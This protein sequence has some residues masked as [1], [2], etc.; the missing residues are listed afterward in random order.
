MKKLLLAGAAFAALIAGPAMAADLGAPVYRAPA[1]Y[2]PVASWTGFYAGFNTGYGWEN[3]SSTATPV[4]SFSS[5]GIT[6]GGVPVVPP[7]AFSQQLNGP[8]FGLH[9]GYNYQ[10]AS[11]V[12]GVEGDFDWAGLNNSAQFVLPDPLL[13]SG[14]TATDGFMAHQSI[15]WL[16]SIRGRLGYAWGASL[17]YVTGGGAWEKVNTNYLLS[18]DTAGG[19]FAESSAASFSNT[20]SG[21]VVGA[22]Y[23][24][25]IN[26]NWI[27]RGEYLHYGFNSG[28]N[29]N[30]IFVACAVGGAA[31]VCGSNVTRNNDNIDVVR[32]G[33]SYKFGGY[34]AAPAFYK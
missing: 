19:V 10:I 23:E 12:V 17:L 14:G 21:Y 31:G 8:L 1:V 16:A 6:T 24:Y 33:L 2:V 18:T 28:S 3:S 9:G 22:G 29:I 26:P 25:M 32:L 20:R 30:P 4:Q 15:Q 5:V 13:G 11:W 7:V 27:V 34:A